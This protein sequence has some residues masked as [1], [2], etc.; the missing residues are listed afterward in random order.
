MQFSALRCNLSVVGVFLAI[1]SLFLLLENILS[2]S[3]PSLDVERLFRRRLSGATVCS[4]RC[5]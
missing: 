1:T 4:D 5:V 3:R 2:L